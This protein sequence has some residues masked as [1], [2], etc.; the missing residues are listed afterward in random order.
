MV[1]LLR[2][3]LNGVAI[4]CALC[5]SHLEY[6]TA[7]WDPHQSKDLNQYNVSHVGSVPKVGMIVAVICCK[8]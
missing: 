3:D 1:Q 2:G 7:V 4:F 5:I 8:R 6:A